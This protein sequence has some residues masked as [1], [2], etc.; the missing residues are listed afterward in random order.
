M[1]K[2]IFTKR[3]KVTI[4]WIVILML[5]YFLL[6][7]GFYISNINLFTKITSEEIIK[8]F[9]SGLRFDFSAI[10]SSNF[11]LLVIY[12]LPFIKLRYKFPR[13]I[14]IFLFILIN[15]F[16]IALN[17]TDYGYFTTTQRRLSYEIIVMSEDIVRIFPYLIVHHYF[18]S[19]LMFLLVILF[20]FLT[21]KFLNYLY[22]KIKE[23]KTISS[24]IISFLIIIGISIVGIR[25][26]LQL[27]PIRPADAFVTDNP[28]TSN[29]TLNTT[30]NVITNIFQNK[31]PNVN[32][33][34][35]VEAQKIIREYIKVENEKFINDE[36]PFLRYKQTNDSI[37]KL[38][39]VIFIMESWSAKYCGY[40]SA[41]KS[42]TPFFD[43]I[44]SKGILFTKFLA[45]GQRSIEAV[46][47]ILTSVPSLFNTSI[48]NSNIEMNR[49]R[50]IGSIMIE[51]GYTTSF[52]HGAT[53]GS[54]GFSGFSKIAGLNNYY[55]K[56]DFNDSLNN[57][58]DG[59]WGIYDEP[60]FI[61]TADILNSTK[62]PF[63]AV[64]FSLSSH[65]PFSLPENRKYIFDK[66]KDETALELSIRYSDYS[67]QKFFNYVSN[68]NWFEN[69][70]FIITA[71]HTLYNS[72]DNFL[73]TY[74]IPLLIYSPKYIPP[75][76]N[77]KICSQVDILPTIL[78]ILN[79]STTHSSMG[80]S[81]L[82]TIKNRFVFNKWGNLFCTF[83]D[84]LVLLTDFENQ[85]ILYNY[86]T[87]FQGKRNLIDIYKEEY[88]KLK[89]ILT[90]YI[91]LSN[92]TI[93]NN[94]IYYEPK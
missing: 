78:D 63:F 66:F 80:I 1:S 22:G 61:Y 58:Y 50:G 14:L 85:N 11:I 23:N 69:T 93:V 49:F 92:Y 47:T 91:Q 77:N 4:I 28:E 60:F 30:F 71:D 65:D 76:I 32:Y 81:M 26:G 35:Q 52:H 27:R 48:I 2:Y 17:I 67:L 56:E 64:I 82:D 19:G 36:Y 42:L 6:R 94:K 39:V 54:M 57:S 45:N 83:S 74:H 13:I 53:T 84:S 70:L 59:A 41:E 18:L 46:P 9:I 5:I 44:A 24:E 34:P 7:I 37:R 62:E 86:I 73:N 15:L 88:N 55:G 31:I 79:I 21:V 43:S 72:R 20:S 25:G 10:L 51:N 29:L 89:L 38:N 12:N 75:S 16:F 90:A 68:F 33:M 3:F 87:D 8:S 40:L